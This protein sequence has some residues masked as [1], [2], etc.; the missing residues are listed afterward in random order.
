VLHYA[1]PPLKILPRIKRLTGDTMPI[2]VDCG[3]K[4]GMD[5]FKALALGASGVCVGTQII[6]GL[7]K[8]G[9]AGVRKVLEDIT[10]EL[11]WAMNLTCSPD[12][13]H[14]DPSVVWT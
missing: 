11:A 5:A 12:T 9:D 8:E 4:S 1:L 3:I 10:E 7:S 2:F 13:A 6:A 14:I